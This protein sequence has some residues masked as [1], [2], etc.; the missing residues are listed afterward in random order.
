MSKKRDLYNMG[1]FGEDDY[2]E[3]IEE[4]PYYNENNMYEDEGEEIYPEMTRGGYIEPQNYYYPGQNDEMYEDEEEDSY[5]PMNDPRFQ[6]YLLKN[7]IIEYDSDDSDEEESEES[8]SESS[9]DDSN[10]KNKKG[11]KKKT[12]QKKKAP[13]RKATK[14]KK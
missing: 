9:D 10:Y 2:N 1:E 11:A 8:S 14:K 7:G 13:K 3:N 12:Q 4:P 6:N 5:Y